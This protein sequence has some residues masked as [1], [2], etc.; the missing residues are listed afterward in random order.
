MFGL[1][2]EK[3]SASTGCAETIKVA[4]NAARAPT[5]RTA[6]QR[7]MT[8]C[9][10]IDFDCPQDQKPA[11][12]RMMNWRRGNLDCGGPDCRWQVASSGEMSTDWDGKERAATAAR[13]DQDSNAGSQS[14]GETSCGCD[15]QR[16]GIKSKRHRFRLLFVCMIF[17]KTGI[18][19]ADSLRLQ[20]RE[21]SALS[22]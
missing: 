8:A 21:F 9:P 19:P 14:F 22:L 12:T 6:R 1:L 4:A 2:H 17:R 20:A 13:S 15:L 18:S 10:T 5:D 16:D 11:T 3:E 7:F